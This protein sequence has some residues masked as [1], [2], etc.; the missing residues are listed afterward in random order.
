M[1]I[2]IIKLCKWVRKY[3]NQNANN[4]PKN[5]NLKTMKCFLIAVCLILATTTSVAEKNNLVKVKHLRCK[6]VNSFPNHRC[7]VVKKPGRG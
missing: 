2:L 4:F 6:K 7:T 3:G 5:E 1:S